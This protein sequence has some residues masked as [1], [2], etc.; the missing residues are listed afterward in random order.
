[1]LDDTIDPDQVLRGTLTP[2]RVTARLR[3]MPI[4][5]DWPTAID[6]EPETAWDLAVDDTSGV[7][8]YLAELRLVDPAEV[9]TLTFALCM[10]DTSV[11]FSLS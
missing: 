5:I 2:V 11:S 1:V 3:A 4:G 9:G 10:P 7:P 6:K 8:L